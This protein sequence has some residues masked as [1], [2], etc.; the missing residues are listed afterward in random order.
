[1]RHVTRPILVVLAAVLAAAQEP[2]VKV[3]VLNVCTPSAE[4]QQEISSALS[5]IPKQPVF[6]PDFEVSRGRSTLSN[7]PA[8]L[9]AGAAA[10]IPPESAT[11]AYVRIRHE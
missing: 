8:L 4:E 7:D 10:Q 9:Q 3:N 5:R 6:G 2:Q 11:A 1:M